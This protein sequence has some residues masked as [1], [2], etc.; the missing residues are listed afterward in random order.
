MQSGKMPQQSMIHGQLKLLRLT[1]LE[2]SVDTIDEGRLRTGHNKV[3]T[4]LLCEC[5]EAGVI[6]ALD[7][8]VGDLGGSTHTSTAISGSDI[9]DVDEGRLAQPPSISMLTATIADNEDA[10]L[11]LSHCI[12]SVSSDC[13]KVSDCGS[14]PR[15]ICPS[16]SDSGG[17]VLN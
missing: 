4:V 1:G 15:G 6:I 13:D 17:E 10:Q 8:G 7:I 3:H 11:F 2:V 9:D 5:D 12:S 16:S 14:P